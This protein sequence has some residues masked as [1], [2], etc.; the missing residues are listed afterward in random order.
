MKFRK[1][2]TAIA[3]VTLI[4]GT[5]GQ[6]S[7][8]I[9]A[10]SYLEIDNLS[11]GFNAP[12]GGDTINNF[13]FDLSNTASLG[14]ADDIDTANCNG[15]DGTPNTGTTNNCNPETNT[16]L[17]TTGTRLDAEHI[18]LGDATY[19]ENGFTL[20]GPGSAEY[21]QSDS[22][23]YTAQLTGDS[24]THTEQY[25]E[26]ELQTGNNAA[27]NAEIQ[28]ATGFVFE[29]SIEDPE[30][31]GVD[32]LFSFDAVWD[33]LAA[34]NDPALGL[35]ATAQ[36]NKR[37]S[38]VLS[39]DVDANSITFLANGDL[40]T[41]C[42]ATGTILSCTETADSGD[43]QADFGVST[44]PNSSG[45]DGSGAFAW[46]FNDLYNGDWTLTLNALT[47][48]SLSRNVE[49]IPE[50]STLLLLGAGLAGLGVGRR[51]RKKHA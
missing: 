40:A 42:V 20:L 9:Y 1:T 30:N 25:A 34:I 26:S 41:G 18:V 45:D 24:S 12:P 2:T 10:R 48:T 35:T 38:F 31:S 39:N 6:A 16:G 19:N 27:A 50:P 29:F 13:N 51:I 49:A 28:S 22:V 4:L 36:A 8:S 17:N 47:S 46:S 23:I 11:I 7:A 3:M 32:M 43:L 5:V 21:S 15:L 14:G 33:T 37:V 44:H